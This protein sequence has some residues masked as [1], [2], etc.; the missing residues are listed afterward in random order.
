[1]AVSSSKT[2]SILAVS[3]SAYLKIIISLVDD[4]PL[5]ESVLWKIQNT[6]VNVV[7]VNVEEKEQC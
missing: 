6:S 7:D 3:H 1:M 4:N 5:A 2:S